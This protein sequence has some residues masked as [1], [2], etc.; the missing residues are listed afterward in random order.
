MDRRQKK[1][2]AAIFRAFR[3]LLTQ[4]RYE[5]ITVQEILDEADVGRSTFYAHFETKDMLL[6]AMCSEIFDHIFTGSLCDYHEDGDTL[7][8]KLSHILW[9][10]YEQKADVLAVLSSDSGE[11]FLQYFKQQLGGVFRLYLQDF[12]SDIPQEYLLCH[13]VG[14]FTET[15]RWCIGSGMAIPPETMA[16]YF[17]RAMGK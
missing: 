11:L 12:P 5:Q 3:T 16:G 4:K 15:V 14:S 9:H 10:L 2:R 1:T 7:H 13:L 6:K 8:A 17:L